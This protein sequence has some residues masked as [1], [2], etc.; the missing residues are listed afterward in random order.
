MVTN[1]NQNDC[2]QR[3]CNADEHHLTHADRIH[4][5]CVQREVNTVNHCQTHT[6]ERNSDRQNNWISVGSQEVDSDFR[7]D[8][9]GQ[10]NSNVKAKV[11][12]ELARPV[13]TGDDIATNADG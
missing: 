6:G 8:C 11:C 10:Q 1:N 7:K 3:N 4:A 9:N 12:R 5:Q 13:D 2:G